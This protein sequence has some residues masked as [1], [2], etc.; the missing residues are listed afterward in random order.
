MREY[1]RVHCAFWTSHDMRSLSEDGRALALY[2]L[3]CPHTTLIGICRLPDGYVSEDLQWTN[4][5]VAKGL[6][7]LFQKGFSNRC[8]TTK[9][10]WIRKYLEWN[11]PENPNQWKAARRIAAQIPDD[12]VWK[13]DFLGIFSDDG[14]SGGNPSETL[15]QGYRNKGSGTGAVT[16]SGKGSKRAPAAMKV[17]RETL[18]PGWWLDF[19]L[20]YPDRAGD[21]GWRKA[22][23]AANSRIAEGHTQ[24]EL[25]AG[26][27]RYA[28]FCDLTGKTGTEYVK[29][30]ATFL[31]PDKHFLEAW[32]APPTKADV[33]LA[34]NLSAAQEF[35]RRT[36]PVQ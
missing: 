1:G 10:I 5:R 7:E 17:S 6:L 15:P 12:C 4:E 20:A 30:A 19:K 8:E 36:E 27:K 26:A 11:A 2:L 32:G 22:Q 25:I 21:H 16:G 9:W 3:T 28:V 23:S 31:G 35:M 34:S 14:E 13:S 24:A 18:T 33:R 29:Q